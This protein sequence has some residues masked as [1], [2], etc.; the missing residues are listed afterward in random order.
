MMVNVAGGAMIAIASPMATATGM[1]AFL[2]VGW[3]GGF[4]TFSTSMLDAVLLHRSGRTPLACAIW[5]GTPV[6]GVGAW[7]LVTALCGGS[8]A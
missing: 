7:L 2:V 6:V 8:S 5:I 1:N 4:T 3:F